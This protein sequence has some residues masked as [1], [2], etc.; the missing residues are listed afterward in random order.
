MFQDDC[1]KMR[2]LTDETHPKFL[3]FK[4]VFDWLADVAVACVERA[5]EQLKHRKHWLI[6]LNSI[7]WLGELE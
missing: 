3:L 2:C 1:L 6:G 4:R 7:K 5:Q